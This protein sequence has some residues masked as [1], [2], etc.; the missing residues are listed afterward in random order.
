MLQIMQ[1]FLVHTTF[2]SLIFLQQLY[3]PP[4]IYNLHSV[5]IALLF[6]LILDHDI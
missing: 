2:Q 3:P 4:L 1:F 6:F 5:I